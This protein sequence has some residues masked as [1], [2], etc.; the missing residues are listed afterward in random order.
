MSDELEYSDG[1]VK[2]CLGDHTEGD[3]N[4]NAEPSQLAVLRCKMLLNWIEAALRNPAYTLTQFFDD[5]GMSGL[6]IRRKT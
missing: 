1:F 6:E 2:H 3:W 4:K 5:K